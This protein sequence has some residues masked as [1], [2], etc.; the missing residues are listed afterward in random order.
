MKSK[1]IV[2]KSSLSPRE[3]LQRLAEAI[4]PDPFLNF[5]KISRSKPVVGTVTEKHWTL[6]KRVQGRNSF[7]TEL[8]ASVRAA[9]D[10]S[11]IVCRFGMNPVV[12]VFSIMWLAGAVTIGGMMFAVSLFRPDPLSP[13][14]IWGLV[15]PP[16]M[17]LFGLFVVG[18]GQMISQGD[19]KFLL[20]FV[21]QTVDGVEDA[22]EA[23]SAKCSN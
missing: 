11:V 10:G 18:I 7:Q 4:D 23:P 6:C 8:T 9:G 14:N 22:N 3:C 12:F 15:A 20:R 13:D 1:P 19:E 2:L 21:K 5:R 16:I 17:I